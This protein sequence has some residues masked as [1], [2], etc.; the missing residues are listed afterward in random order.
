MCV[1]CCLLVAKWGCCALLDLIV[2]DVHCV[3]CMSLCL[4]LCAE[5]LYVVCVVV[6]CLLFLV[7]CFCLRMAVVGVGRSLVMV[8]V[9]WSCR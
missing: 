5:L 9:V 6:T 7:G 2:V 8:A 3:C 4:C 1:V